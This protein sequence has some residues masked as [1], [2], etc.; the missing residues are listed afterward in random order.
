MNQIKAITYACTI[1]DH[2]GK[3]VL[4]WYLRS[5][6]TPVDKTKIENMDLSNIIVMLYT[7]KIIDDSIKVKIME[8]TGIRNSFIHHGAFIKTTSGKRKEFDN[9]AR[10]ALECVKFIKAKL[11]EELK[12]NQ[13][14]YSQNLII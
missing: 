12:K 9:A 8:V 13:Q 4:V 10:H 14:S 5:N 2:Y 11:D 6:G 3:Q 1:F 7:H